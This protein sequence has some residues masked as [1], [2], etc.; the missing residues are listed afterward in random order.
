M[1][2]KPITSR[3]QLVRPRAASQLAVRAQPGNYLAA[4]PQGNQD[5]EGLIRGLAALNPAL[6]GL[7]A[8]RAQQDQSFA[9]EQRRG[10]QREG[11]AFAQSVQNPSEALTGGPI[12]AP[13]ALPSAVSD[14]FRGAMYEQLAARAG[15]ETKAA[16][17][18]EY[19]QHKDSPDFNP[20]RWLQEKRQAALAG[21]TDPTAATIIGKHFTEFEAY[22]EADNRQRRMQRADDVRASMVTQLAADT[23]T[24]D[25]SP[26]QISEAFPGFLAEARRAGYSAKDGAQF[27]FTQVVAA[28]N[29]VG[30]SPELF[31][32]FDRKDAEGLT[33]QARNPQLGPL[34]EQAR[35]HAKTLRDRALTEAAEEGNTKA[36][37]DLNRDLRE[38]PEAVTQDRI[39]QMMGPFGA[40][41]SPE[42]AA[43]LFD[44]AQ[45]ALQK[46]QA[47][48]SVASTFDTGTMFWLDPQ[49]QGK[50]L[51]LRLGTTVKRMVQAVQEG[52]EA[53]IT[54]AAAVLMQA[55]SSARATVPVESVARLTKTLVAN[56]PSREGPTPGFLAGAALYRALSANPQ[57]RTLYFSEEVGKVLEGFNAETSN[58]TDAKA[59]YEMAY[60]STSP[61][62]KAA[63]EAYAKSPEFTKKLAGDVKKYVEGSSWV[64]QWIGG[65]GRPESNGMLQVS[66][67]NEVR[68][69]RTRNPHATDAETDAY[70]EQWTQ[71]NFVLDTTTGT[72]IKVPPTLSG[73]ATQEALSAYTKKLAQAYR[74]ADRNDAEWKPMLIP[75]GTEGAYAVTLWNGS[76]SHSVGTVSLQQLL[77]TE[78]ARKVFSHEEL[79]S[80]G[81]AKRAIAEGQA[82]HVLP[83]ELLSKAEGLGVFKPAELKAYKDAA[84]TQFLERMRSVPSISFGAP[85]ADGVQFMPGK[86]VKV[87]AQ[88][89][90]R[91]ALDFA[92]SPMFS[93]GTQH[94]GLAASLITMG[95]GVVLAAYDDPAEGAGRNIGTGY[96]LKANAKNAPADLRQAGV[97]PERI[98]DVLD[99][100]AQLTVDQSKRLTQVAMVRYEKQAREA[101]EGTGAGLWA[102][103]TPEQKAVMID[104]AW[105]VGSPERFTK[106]WAAVAANDAEALARE[107]RVFYT[108]RS[109][110][111]REDKRRN[112]LRASMLAGIPHWE[113][114][115]QRFGA[116]PGNKLQALAPVEVK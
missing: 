90:S 52:D 68:A 18:A 108:D 8:A 35:G 74:T 89:T 66:V 41:K 31:D 26:D 1:T 29:R 113:A 58:G 50:V 85:S 96:N 70:V 7:S 103:M 92:A 39:L 87:D 72:A 71:R 83:P 94:Q 16:A 105:Q 75:Q 76:A 17:A 100:R 95:E 69:Y 116:A 34:V 4:L 48:E 30:G 55:H 49:Q 104:V 44:A 38:Q 54:Q 14:E 97:P 27:L 20:Q 15:I 112:S 99:G 107:T 73:P 28:S 56:L 82:L 63:A 21:V 106:A 53:G 84:R 77:E 12:Q 2:D 13:A 42:R 62:A 93:A 46:K 47:A 37:I 59:A 25:K 43:A 10:D 67:A 23:F 33:L 80:I 51:D 61:E 60:R 11:A 102:R 24:A 110:E 65:N 81:R 88:L 9:A 22:V 3:P 91:V 40:I 115:V 109:G 6:A 79:A 98:A 111:R 19:D 114:L 64:P 36:L 5:A 45:E 57:Y 101:A 86:P 32:V 78:R